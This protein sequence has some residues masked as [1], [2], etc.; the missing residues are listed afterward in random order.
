MVGEGLKWPG[1]LKEI[2]NDE[3]GREMQKRIASQG[4]KFVCRK[5]HVS[6]KALRDKLRL[7]YHER[8]ERYSFMETKLVLTHFL[9]QSVK[10]V[11]KIKKIPNVFVVLFHGL[12]RF[13]VELFESEN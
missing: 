5:I 6:C 9:N 2:H 8:F 1:K 4:C 12:R 7:G 13:W 10:T 3:T 11:F